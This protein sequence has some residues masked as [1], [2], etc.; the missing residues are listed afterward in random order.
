GRSTDGQETTGDDSFLP[1]AR[2]TAEYPDH[3]ERAVALV[4]PDDFPGRAIAVVCPA[5]RPAARCPG[6]AGVLP[7]GG[8]EIPCDD[9]DEG[10]GLRRRRTRVQLLPRQTRLVG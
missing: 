8:T 7:P 10:D 2:G 5:G 9:P 4:H 3:P 1:H 6:G